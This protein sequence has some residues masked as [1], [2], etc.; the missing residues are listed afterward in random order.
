MR[1]ERGWAF[2][3]LTQQR[4]MFS[5]AEKEGGGQCV[6]QVKHPSLVNA[7]VMRVETEAVGVA[8]GGWSPQTPPSPTHLQAPL[9]PLEGAPG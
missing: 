4:S 6:S 9:E 2:V 3:G 8:W 7:P 1:V 5:G